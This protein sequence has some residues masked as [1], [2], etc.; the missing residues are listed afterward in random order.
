MRIY[1]DNDCHNPAAA[2]SLPSGKRCLRRLDSWLCYLAFPLK[3]LLDYFDSGIA[4][5]KPIEYK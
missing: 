3:H 2:Y 1:P 5:I 4:A